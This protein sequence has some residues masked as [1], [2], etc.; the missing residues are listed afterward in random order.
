M[1]LHKLGW[2]GD[3]KMGDSVAGLE[4]KL[5]PGNQSCSVTPAAIYEACSGCRF[6]CF[7]PASLEEMGVVPGTKLSLCYEKP[8]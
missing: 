4:R 5:V 3:G 1:G 7:L 8:F 6:F 2:W